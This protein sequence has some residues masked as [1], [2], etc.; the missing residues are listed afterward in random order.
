M[1]VKDAVYKKCKECGHQTLLKDEEICCDGCKK[2]LDMDGKVEYLHSTV[3]PDTTEQAI[4]Y[5]FCSWKCF[6]KVSKKISCKYFLNVPYLRY[7]VEGPTGAK[8]FWKLVKK[9]IG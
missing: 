9:G 3:F 1:V 4:H 2:E 5:H 8:E 7:S 6:F